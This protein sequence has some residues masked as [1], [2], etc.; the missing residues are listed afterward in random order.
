MLKFTIDNS[1]RDFPIHF[2]GISLDY[3][4]CLL[5][6]QYEKSYKCSDYI[7]DCFV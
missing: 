5:F 7:K 1:K 3:C 6:V 4:V 2:F